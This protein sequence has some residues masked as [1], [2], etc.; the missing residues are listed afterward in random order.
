MFFASWEIS[1]SPHSDSLC[2]LPV[3]VIEVTPKGHYWQLVLQPIEWGNTPISAV[4]ND[5]TS[6]PHKGDIYYKGG[7]KAR[8]THKIV[9]NNSFTGIHSLKIALFFYYS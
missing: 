1:L 7:A 4:W 5:M 8:L 2:K 6:I 9:P 3:K